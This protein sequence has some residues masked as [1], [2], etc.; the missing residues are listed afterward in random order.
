MR[1]HKVRVEKI[2]PFLLNKYSIRDFRLLPVHVTSLTCSLRCI[3]SAY[4][5]HQSLDKHNLG[6]K[7]VFFFQTH[8]IQII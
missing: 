1:L 3:I 2:S 6:R 7:I 4:C 5:I 8:Q